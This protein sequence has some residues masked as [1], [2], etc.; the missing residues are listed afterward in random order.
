MSPGRHTTS[1][2]IALQ[3]LA[4]TTRGLTVNTF[5][6]L[7]DIF[8]DRTIARWVVGVI[9]GLWLLFA[10]TA[11]VY[12]K[13]GPIIF[14]GRLINFG[15]ILPLL[16]FPSIVALFLLLAILASFEKLRDTESTIER[17]VREAREPELDVHNT[18]SASEQQAKTFDI[19]EVI[20]S[21][22]K[23]LIDYYIINKAQAT[24]SF[25]SSIVAIGMGFATITLGIWLAYANVGNNTAAYISVLAGVVLQF[26]GGAFFFLYNKSLIQLNFFFARLA[27][28]QDTML[29]IRLAESIPAGKE[30]HQILEKLIFA[31]VQRNAIVPDYL[32]T[33]KAESSSK[34]RNA[35]AKS[36]EE[37]AD[38]RR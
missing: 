13:A 24:T 34:R 3:I 31:I 29:G 10:L 16:L 18:G 33:G 28:M 32:S 26:I 20:E 38:S 4:E 6:G 22:L 5:A 9:C 17:M 14:L 12:I 23:Q 2:D 8:R 7:G 25:R 35:K 37:P 15:T 11:G 21:N 36:E 30:K 19:L 27:L 1:T